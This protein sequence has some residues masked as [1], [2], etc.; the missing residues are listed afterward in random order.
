MYLST[1][2]PICRWDVNGDGEL[3]EAELVS[4]I[5]SEARQSTKL[6]HLKTYLVVAVAMLGASI[7]S[8]FGTSYCKFLCA[9]VRG[10]STRD[11]TRHC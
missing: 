5:R 10:V 7:A 11:P 1:Y 8:N 6:N 3:D 4:A 2:T 9:R